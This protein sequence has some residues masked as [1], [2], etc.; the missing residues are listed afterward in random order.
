MHEQTASLLKW[1]WAWSRLAADAFHRV[2]LRT[3]NEHRLYTID[4]QI[5]IAFDIIPS[6]RQ[7]SQHRQSSE[8]QRRCK[9]ETPTRH[10]CPAAL[11]S[12]RVFW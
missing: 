7:H 12:P 10:G 2:H 5:R 8:L 4:I 11:L 9:A 6:R 1:A 3:T